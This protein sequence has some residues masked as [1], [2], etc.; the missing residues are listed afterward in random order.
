MLGYRLFPRLVSARI[1]ANFECWASNAPRR[2]PMGCAFAPQSREENRR[3]LQ[4]E[5]QSIDRCF[6]QKLRRSSGV[7]IDIECHLPQWKDGFFAIGTKIGA[8]VGRFEFSTRRPCHDGVEIATRRAIRIGIDF[9]TNCS[10]GHGIGIA[11]RE[12]LGHGIGI[13]VD[14]SSCRWGETTAICIVVKTGIAQIADKI[15]VGCERF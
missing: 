8:V 7:V 1:R 13:A 11:T 12:T 2:A 9:A 5:C 4:I 3:Q 15:D 10:C 6:A 14:S